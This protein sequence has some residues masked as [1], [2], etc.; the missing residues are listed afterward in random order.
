M[1]KVVILIVVALILGTVV[2][3]YAAAGSGDEKR[4]DNAN[5]YDNGNGTP[6][7]DGQSRSESRLRFEDR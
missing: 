4:T 5:E 2:C 6:P 7:D 1:N 3:G